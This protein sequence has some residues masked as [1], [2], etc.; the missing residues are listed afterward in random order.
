MRLDSGQRT[1]GRAV[2]PR[3]G[4][5][6]E[7]R[8]VLPQRHRRHHEA[9]VGDEKLRRDDEPVLYRPRLGSTATLIGSCLL[10]AA[11]NAFFLSS[12]HS[13]SAFLAA[14]TLAFLLAERGRWVAAGVAAA[15]ALIRAPGVLLLLPLAALRPVGDVEEQQAVLRQAPDV[16]FVRLP[17]HN[18]ER[19]RKQVTAVVAALAAPPIR[20][21]VHLGVPLPP[22]RAALLHILNVDPERALAL[23]EEDQQFVPGVTPSRP[24]PGW[25]PAAR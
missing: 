14:T 11:P 25:S 10:L 15:A 21:G 5:Q 20:L 18:P 13:E 3:V 22:L 19:V 17:V 16:F 24:C 6:G 9:G 1:R 8:E 2:T 12:G 23:K 7:R 4:D